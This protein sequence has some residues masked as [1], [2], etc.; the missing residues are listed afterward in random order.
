[1]VVYVIA[2]CLRQ[3]IRNKINLNN[4]FLNY[5]INHIFPVLIMQNNRQGPLEAEHIENAE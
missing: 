3:K 1:M 5:V 4:M 2:A